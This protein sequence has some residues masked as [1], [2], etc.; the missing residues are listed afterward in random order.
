VVAMSDE[1][2]DVLI[3][4]DYVIKSYFCISDDATGESIQIHEGT[5][6]GDIPDHVKESARSHLL[7]NQP[8]AHTPILLTPEGKE[9]IINSQLSEGYKT[10]KRNAVV[11][12]KEQNPEFDKKPLIK[13]GDQDLL[14]TQIIEIFLEYNAIFECVFSHDGILVTVIRTKDMIRLKPLSKAAF[15]RLLDKCIWLL[16]GSGKLS[17]NEDPTNYI[18]IPDHLVAKAL[19]D[20]ALHTGVHPII[21]VWPMPLLLN[22]GR[23]KMHDG[24]D[25]ES[26]L[27][28]VI[29]ENLKGMEIPL[30]D[31]EH[32]VHQ[33]NNDIMLP[34]Y[35]GV[36]LKKY[37][38]CT[39]DASIHNEIG[40][41][42][43]TIFK[44]LYPLMP[45][46][47][48]ATI[49]TGKGQGGTLS[50]QRIA[51]LTTG[52][53]ARMQKV[54]KADKWEAVVSSNLANPSSILPFDNARGHIYD[55]TL[56]IITTS[57]RLSYRPYG[58][59]GRLIDGVFN[60]VIFIN[61]INITFTDEGA[62]RIVTSE[63]V[64][65]TE[66]DKKNR[67]YEN[68]ELYL[69]YLD[70]TIQEKIGHL[71][72]CASYYQR[73]GTSVKP[74]DHIPQIDSFSMYRRIIGGCLH[75]M[76]LNAF[77]TNLKEAN[78]EMDR[79]TKQLSLFWPAIAEN[80]KVMEFEK[81]QGYVLPSQIYE[82]I[83]RL[84]DG[85]K[86]WCN[87]PELES[88]IPDVYNLS[89]QTNLKGFTSVLNRLIEDKKG[90]VFGGVSLELVARE[91][92]TS[93]KIAKGIV[94]NRG[95][96]VWT[97]CPYDAYSDPKPMS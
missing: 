74:M 50:M 54:P 77:L 24:Y 90:Q 15:E 63:L 14:V 93:H 34:L 27:Y 4:E 92:K 75:I 61:G 10:A 25:H 96:K 62:R 57:S 19:E 47:I 69:N 89:K 3:D 1:H 60:K 51:R 85:D 35:K 73:R 59:N 65:P 76:G 32:E 5:K 20:E 42:M 6:L 21:G 29:P 40:G 86:E 49:K 23:V 83:R 11:V 7:A 22:D 68:E 46:P 81:E 8:A 9:A 17:P 56:N 78:K 33:K 30:Y 36:S 16:K 38:N 64:E 88:L 95:L 48:H 70:E 18:R 91:S 37:A 67:L 87:E 66:E 53:E 52:K 12:P 97:K 26:Q 58:E 55:E 45:T 79:D 44:G 71:Y 2:G 94:I 13:H 31:S 43:A 39:P 72:G 80:P 82:L 28:V 84:K 41:I